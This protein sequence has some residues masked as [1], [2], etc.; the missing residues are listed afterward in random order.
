[1]SDRLTGKD[2]GKLAEQAVR[3]IAA[4]TGFEQVALC[5][6]NGNKIACNRS[7]A[8][9]GL[10][11]CAASTRL[12]ADCEAEPVPIVGAD[13]MGLIERAAYLAP[14]SD[15]CDQLRACG[16]AA[17]MELPLRIDGEQIA[18]LNC[19]HSSARR[20][21]AERRSVAH[22]FSERLVARMARQGWKP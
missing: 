13:E 17:A 14:G 8:Q 12:V 9:E 10:L 18:T 19:H 15:R 20:I 7:E 21:G 1:M 4:L 2:P 6:R 22:L 5:D 16:M 11:E 3:Q